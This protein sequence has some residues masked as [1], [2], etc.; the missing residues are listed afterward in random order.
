MACLHLRF[1]SQSQPNIFHPLSPCSLLNYILSHIAFP[2]SPA[3]FIGNT[4]GP[5]IS[6]EAN[7]AQG[8]RSEVA[9]VQHQDLIGIHTTLINTTSRNCAKNCPMH[10]Y[11]FIVGEMMWLPVWQFLKSPKH[12]N[13]SVAVDICVTK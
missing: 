8:L 6:P 5:P 2:P 9:A 3:C 1:V 7:S 10:G 13:C 11:S 4:H 12:L